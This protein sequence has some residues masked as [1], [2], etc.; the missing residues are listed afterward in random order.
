MNL[1]HESDARKTHSDAFEKQDLLII[2][3]QTLLMYANS[4]LCGRD[5]D[6]NFYYYERV[7]NLY[8]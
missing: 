7:I 3:L 5:G 6:D 4:A 2:N 1:S 8:L